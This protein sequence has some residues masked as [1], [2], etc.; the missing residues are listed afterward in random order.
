ML[1]RVWEVLNYLPRNLQEGRTINGVVLLDLLRFLNLFEVL[2]IPKPNYF[3]DLLQVSLE[4]HRGGIACVDIA[5]PQGMKQRQSIA[6]YF[7]LVAIPVEVWPDGERL[8]AV[9]V[10]EGA[11][12]HH[13][14]LLL[15]LNS[16]RLVFPDF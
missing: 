8:T 7:F 11:A 16:Q 5:L 2:R 10:V 9:A 4:H 15:V 14:P 13:R 1:C 3:R 12:S 6:T